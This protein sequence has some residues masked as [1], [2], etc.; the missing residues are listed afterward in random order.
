VALENP[1]DRT[2]AGRVSFATRPQRPVDRAGAELAEV[3]HVL[4][5][6]PQSKNLD[7]DLGRYPVDDVSD[8]RTVSPVDT[9]QPL[10]GRTG[11]PSLHGVQTHLQSPSDGAESKAAP[12]HCHHS[13][14][15]LFERSFLGMV[16]Y[17]SGRLLGA[18]LWKLPELWTQRAAS[19]SSLENAKSA[20]ST[21]TTGHY[22][23]SG[24]VK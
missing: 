15:Q 9:I 13:S 8:G 18:G 3:A 6:A 17:R 10:V 12:D 22:P 20:F 4:Q 11:N 21:A 16:E 1:S 19:T 23:F 5:L 24:S 14:A 2:D 7:F